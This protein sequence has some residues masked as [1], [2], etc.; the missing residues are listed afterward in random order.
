MK[1]RER[2]DAIG[3]EVARLTDV[4]RFTQTEKHGF[5]LDYRLRLEL[6]QISKGLQHLGYEYAAPA[7]LPLV[8]LIKRE[9]R[10]S[11]KA[12]GVDA[13]DIVNRVHSCLS[14]HAPALRQVENSSGATNTLDARVWDF[15]TAQVE[16]YLFGPS[17]IDL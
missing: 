11:A 14:D 17:T 4:L 12:G 5:A 9:C 15:V 1:L 10:A 13:G 2:L 16:E 3:V 8:E 7:Q 6:Y